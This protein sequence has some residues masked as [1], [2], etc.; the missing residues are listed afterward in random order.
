MLVIGA[1]L[2]FGNPKVFLHVSA[3]YFARSAFDKVRNVEKPLASVVL[4]IVLGK[5]FIVARAILWWRL[6]CTEYV[7][8]RVPD[9]VIPFCL[10]GTWRNL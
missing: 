2:P 7:W 9:I 8:V 5:I 4:L 6:R 10:S 3:D 1:N